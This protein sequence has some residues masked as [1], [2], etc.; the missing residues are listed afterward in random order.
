MVVVRWRDVQD[1]VGTIDAARA[2]FAAALVGLVA[3]NFV[4]T[5]FFFHQLIGRFGRV[6]IIEMQAVMAS[7][8]LLNYLPLRPGLFGRLAYHQ[9]VNGISLRDGARSV[10]ES[11]GISAVLA[12]WFAGSVGLAVRLG[13]PTA[14]LAAIPPVVIAA[15]ALWP[16]CRGLIVPAIIRWGEIG[17]AAGRIALS[18][19]ILG[20]P[21]TLD[22]ALALA[23]ISVVVA[24]VPLS[25]NGLGLKEWT[26][27]LVAP[28]LVD[29]PLEVGVT[30]VL[31]ERAAELLVALPAG[32]G[33]LAVVRR[34]LA[35]AR[36]DST[37]N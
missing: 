23:S 20:V 33:G 6:G 10:V 9:R 15:G 5:G 28:L 12:C 32:L 35:G 19:A 7:A 8:T 14:G 27:G 22:S 3:L 25:S 11:I 31:L 17:L 26:V 2:P 37:E 21:L 16:R 29:V 24:M 34:R 18:F 13:L 1:A 4:T 30:A 36:V